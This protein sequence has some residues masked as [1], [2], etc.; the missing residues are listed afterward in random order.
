VLLAT[1]LLGG[2]SAGPAS[3]AEFTPKVTVT[4]S[5]GLDPAGGTEVVIKGTGFDPDA[6]G[7]KGF[8]LR[9]SP[10]KA[11]VRDRTGTGFQVAKLIR[12]NP[13]GVQLPLD[14]A[15]N[16]EFKIA[17][18]SEYTSGGATFS[19]K[20]QPFSVFVF[21][22]DTPDLAWDSKTPLSFTG[23]GEPEPEPSDAGLH[24]GIRQAWRSY[25][26]RFGGTATPSKGL[27]VNERSPYVWPTDKST[28]DAKTGKGTVSFGGQM[29]FVLEPHFI[30]DFG[31]AGPKVT[32]NGDGTGSLSGV[33]NYAF[34]GTKAAPEEVRA[35]AE[36]VFAD[37]KFKGAPR[38]DDKNVV[39]DIE[40]AKLTEAGAGAF[41]GFYAAG[42]E[43]DAGN[44]AFP[45]TVDVVDPPTTTPPTTTPPPATEPPATTP[46]PP[47]CV[48]DPAAVKQGNLLWGFKK[49]FRQYVGSGAG[50]T[51]AASDG[52]E[53]TN[54]DVVAG[55]GAYRFG[56]GSARYVSAAE[57]SAQ[58]QGKVTFT[59]PAHFFVL[60]LANPKIAVAQGKGTVFADVELTTTTGAGTPPVSK[61][62]VAL[63]TLDLATAKT[64]EGEGTVTVSE[65]KAALT[66]SDAFG[67]FY[68]AGDVLDDVAAT[69]GADCAK[70]PD[71]GPGT[72]GGGQVGG[73]SGDDLV[74]EVA[75]RPSGSANNLASTGATLAPL[76]LGLLLLAAGCALVLFTRRRAR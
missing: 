38:Q 75:Y 52:A 9:I 10:D 3:A 70:L 20:T 6:N 49:S 36:V 15:G 27:V 43:L 8:G 17:V 66:S 64:V 33:V 37:L 45:G 23:L 67:G 53:V 55:Q 61:P 16:W 74:P 42:T 31:F 5:A 76:S 41:A 1:A 54:V 48:F 62:G 65:I 11:D 34:Y 24:W 51:I 59:Y 30:W 47:A 28:W 69:L 68:Q 14:A 22:W 73:G 32:L 2:V 72:P 50:N 57:F 63:A 19:A 21:G 13:V 71:P 26:A 44:F 58:Y 40:S 35:P 60:T 12:K 4:P 25:V 18:K 7:G 56:F 46:V 29:N 39:V